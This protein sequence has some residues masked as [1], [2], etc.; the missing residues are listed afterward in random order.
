MLNS[1]E[2]FLALKTNLRTCGNFI[3]STD[4]PQKDGETDKRHNHIIEKPSQP[5]KNA[6]TPTGLVKSENLFYYFYE[7]KINKLI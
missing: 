5:E 4:A 6:I 3:L 2:I 1:F 7:I